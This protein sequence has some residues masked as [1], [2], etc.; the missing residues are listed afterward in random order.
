MKFYDKEIYNLNEKIQ[1]FI[2]ILV[3]FLASFLLGYWCKNEEYENKINKQEI[4]I[5]DLKEQIDRKEKEEI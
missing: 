3:V 4:E 5:V 2:T 1:A